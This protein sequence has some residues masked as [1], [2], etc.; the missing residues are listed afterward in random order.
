MNKKKFRSHR[1]ILTDKKS[2]PLS[3]EVHNKAWRGLRRNAAPEHVAKNIGTYMCDQMECCCGWK[4]KSFFDG[5]GWAM[6][7]WRE[8]VADEMGLI[9][10]KCPCG[11][12]YIPANGGKPCHELTTV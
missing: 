6:D 4:S 2:W 3:S 9:P 1:A 11:K 7:E 10:K 12:Q 5:A 8:H